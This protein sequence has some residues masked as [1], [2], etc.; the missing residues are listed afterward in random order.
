V[1]SNEGGAFSDVWAALKV[2]EEDRARFLGFGSGCCIRARLVSPSGEQV[3]FA[4]LPDDLKR[5]I[6][7]ARFLNTEN[8]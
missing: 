4:G 1:F 3:Q 5:G 7:K 2:L 6:V 8:G